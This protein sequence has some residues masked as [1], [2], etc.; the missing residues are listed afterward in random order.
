VRCG[1]VARIGWLVARGWVASEVRS[2][3]DCWTP[4]LPFKLDQD[5][6][7]SRVGRPRWHYFRGPDPPAGTRMPEICPDRLNARENRLNVSALRSGQH[8]P[9]D[10]V[11][12]MSSAP[13]Q[14][15]YFRL[16]PMSTASVDAISLRSNMA[17][18]LSCPGCRL[19]RP[20]PCN[21]VTVSCIVTTV[22]NAPSGRARAPGSAAAETFSPGSGEPRC[23]WARS[24]L[25]QDARQ[26]SAVSATRRRLFDTVLRP[27]H[28][29]TVQGARNGV[30]C[31]ARGTS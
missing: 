22:S 18:S 19:H 16:G 20:H 3:T 11:R 28:R 30:G 8:M 27:Q 10:Q 23:L 26:Q 14:S 9:E 2:S 6:R 21:N 15:G 25:G 17:C 5:R 29:P 12:L 7:H 13:V 31:T 24:R 1:L 4:T